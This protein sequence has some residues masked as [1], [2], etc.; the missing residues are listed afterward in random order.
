MEPTPAT[1]PRGGDARLFYLQRDV[2]VSGVSGTGIVAWGILFPGNVVAL[3]WTSKWPTSVV[4]HER[5]IES[6][7]AVHGHDGKTRI[8]WLDDAASRAATA[9]GGEEALLREVVN[10]IDQ[11][12]EWQDLDPATGITTFDMA[13]AAALDDLFALRDRLDARLAGKGE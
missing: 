2:D 8:V 1:A 7:E 4:F 12:E 13:H 10:H 9:R 6:V 5:G 11:V 3:R